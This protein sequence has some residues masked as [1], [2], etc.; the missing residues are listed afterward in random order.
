MHKQLSL[1]EQG[2]WCNR[3]LHMQ[4]LLCTCSPRS[5]WCNGVLHVQSNGLQVQREWLHVQQSSAQAGLLVQRHKLHVQGWGCWCNA[6]GCTC[7]TKPLFWRFAPLHVQN[8][9]NFGPTGVSTFLGRS[10]YIY[11]YIYIYIYICIKKAIILISRGHLDL[12]RAVFQPH[13]QIPVERVC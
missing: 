10:V 4:S 1:H 6:N 3:V 12:Y 2:C 13:P 5:C 9:C 7:K 8:T 11:T